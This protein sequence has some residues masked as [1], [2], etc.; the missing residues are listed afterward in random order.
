[1]P[2]TSR[3]V[4]VTGAGAGSEEGA[5]AGGRAAVTDRTVVAEA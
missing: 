3:G 1:M 2:T 4:E 5:G